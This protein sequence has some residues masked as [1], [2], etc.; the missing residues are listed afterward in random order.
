MSREIL[1]ISLVF[2]I[3]RNDQYYGPE[4]PVTTRRF[5]CTAEEEATQKPH[6][7]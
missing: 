5:L 7:L 1:S 2:L 3:I 4:E 6:W